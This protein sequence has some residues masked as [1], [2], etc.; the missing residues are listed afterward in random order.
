MWHVRTIGSTGCPG[1]WKDR[2][3]Y[4]YGDTK[5]W[6]I[7]D[8]S[9]GT[10]MDLNNA[11]SMQVAVGVVDLCR[12]WCGVLG[13]GACHSPAP[14]ID[15]VQIVRV[16]V[17]GPQWDVRNVDLYQDTFSADGTITGTARIDTAIDSK[18]ATSPTYTPGDSA[19]VLYLLDPK[20]VNPTFTTT[21]SGLLNDPTLSTYLGRNKTKN[22]VYGYF[23][24][25]PFTADKIGP[26]ISDG[27]GGSANRYPF[28]GTISVAGRT[29]AKVRMDYTYLPVL[30]PPTPGYGT[31]TQPRVPQRFNIDIKSGGA[32]APLAGI[33]GLLIRIG[34]V[35]DR[36][37]DEPRFDGEVRHHHPLAIADG[38]HHADLELTLVYR[39]DGDD[40]QPRDPDDQAHAQERLEQ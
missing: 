13:S 23:T 18:P 11:V 6:T 9:V 25:Q 1:P 32:V 14:Y 26:A 28:M 27:P 39:T 29:W 2:G 21:S 16:N 3:I 36:A 8:H 12:M 19:I 5:D 7:A 17:V 4:Y 40:S 34:G 20:Y 35:L 38:P 24:V 30:N 31:G 22:A 10:K 15:S 37:L 33:D